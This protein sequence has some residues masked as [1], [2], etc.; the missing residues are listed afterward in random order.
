MNAFLILRNEKVK[1]NIP[2]ALKNAVKRLSNYLFSEFL[3][4]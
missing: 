4:F 2:K 3:V 1:D